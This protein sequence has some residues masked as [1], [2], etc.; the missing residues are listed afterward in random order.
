MRYTSRPSSGPV[1]KPAALLWNIHGLN[2]ISRL[3]RIGA[4]KLFSHAAGLIV[5]RLTTSATSASP[6]G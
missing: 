3:K 1:P 4:E 5:S 6:V 2:R